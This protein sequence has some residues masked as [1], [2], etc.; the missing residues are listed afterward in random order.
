MLK[1]AQLY[2]DQLREKNIE[3][4]Y[5]PENIFWNEGRRAE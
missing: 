4:W 2:A 1:A 3:A 5:R